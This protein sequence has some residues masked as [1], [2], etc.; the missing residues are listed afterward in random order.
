MLHN[1]A[2]VFNASFA[3]HAFQVALPTLTIGRIGEHKI[4]G[5]AGKGIIGKGRVLRPADNII[6]SL[7]FTLEQKVGLADSVGFRIDLLAEKMHRN[8]FAAFPRQLQEGFLG[9]CEHSA[10]AAGSV[11]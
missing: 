9:Y 8:L 2:R 6:G 3:A 10:G 11:I 5:A 4:E 7:P 1:K